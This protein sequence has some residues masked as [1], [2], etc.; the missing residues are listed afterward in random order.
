MNNERLLKGL[1]LFFI[2]VLKFT[3]DLVDMS[4]GF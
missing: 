4:D 3:L 2:L 1:L